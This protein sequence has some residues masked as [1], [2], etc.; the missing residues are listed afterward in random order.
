MA[1]LSSDRPWFNISQLDPGTAYKLKVYVAHGPIASVPVEVSAYTSNTPLQQPSRPTTSANYGYESGLVATGIG[2]TLCFIIVIAVI[3]RRASLESARNTLNQTL[4]SSPKS[5]LTKSTAT[6]TGVGGDEDGLEVRETDLGDLE[7]MAGFE[8]KPT[9][10]GTSKTSSSSDDSVRFSKIDMNSRY[11]KMH[12]SSSTRFDSETNLSEHQLMLPK[13]EK[14]F[15]ERLSPE[16][17]KEENFDDVAESVGVTPFTR[18]SEAWMDL[19]SDELIH[20]S[21]REVLLTEMSSR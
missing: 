13:G 10:V 1:N 17:R 11:D 16:G 4:N 7:D 8:K 12:L 18:T 19:I 14:F 2:V 6:L 5:H 15:S 20:T 9:C 3:I 21:P